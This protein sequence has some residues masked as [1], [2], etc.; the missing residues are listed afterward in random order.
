MKLYSYKGDTV[1]DPFNGSGQTTKIAFHF[2]RHYIGID[3]VKEYV[4]L[5][6]SR[7]TAEPLHIR[8]E[9]LIA[10]WKKIP[11]HHCFHL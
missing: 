8:S 9:A 3:I 2:K 1:L 4:N 6:R 7:I 11:S 10:N 5:A